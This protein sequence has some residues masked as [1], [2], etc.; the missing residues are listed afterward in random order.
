MSNYIMK[1]SLKIL[2]KILITPEN[3]N[4]IDY[5]GIYMYLDIRDI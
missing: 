2:A 1:C 5:I 3:F 4:K